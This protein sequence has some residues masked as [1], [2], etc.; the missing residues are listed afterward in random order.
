VP[1]PLRYPGRRGHVALYLTW[2]GAAAAG[3]RSVR[4]SEG[5]ELIQA[6]D[7]Q[8]LDLETDL[9]LSK[10]VYHAVQ[11]V[12]GAGLGSGQIY[13][14]SNADELVPDLWRFLQL[15]TELLGLRHAKYKEAL[16][17]LSTRIEARLPG[18]PE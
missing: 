13:L 15:L 8:G 9:V 17:Q 4:I 16:V 12:P 10:T 18:P 2:S 3:P 11:E 6:L 5:G 14:D 7:E 1:L